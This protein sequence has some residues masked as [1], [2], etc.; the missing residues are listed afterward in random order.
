M[1]AFQTKLKVLAI[2]F[3][4]LGVGFNFTSCGDESELENI[5]ET[6]DASG[7]FDSLLVALQASGRDVTWRQSGPYTVFAPVDDVFAALP[8]Q[9][10]EQLLL[11]VPALR[12]I[13]D[14]HIVYGEYTS[15]DL[16]A[17]SGSSLTSLF[18]QNLTVTVQGGMVFINEAPVVVADIPAKNGLVHGIGGLLIPNVPE[19]QAFLQ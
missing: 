7:G 8:P 11:V 5:V 17:M 6:M 16:V 12:A 14:Y 13:L 3:L 1:K 18:G 19:I 4:I 15:E 10:V 9:L 2:L